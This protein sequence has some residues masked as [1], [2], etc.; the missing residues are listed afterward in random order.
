MIANHYALVLFKAQLGEIF[1]ESLI[2]FF[3]FVAKPALEGPKP[4]L[5]KEISI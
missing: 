3:V 5:E 4:A 2:F 1:L